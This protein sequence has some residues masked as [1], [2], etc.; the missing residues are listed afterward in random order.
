VTS[1]VAKCKLSETFV[2]EFLHSNNALI[3]SNSGTA[4]IDNRLFLLGKY[5]L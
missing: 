4:A 3:S 2:V 5:R 1:G